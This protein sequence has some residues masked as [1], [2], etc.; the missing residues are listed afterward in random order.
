MAGEVALAGASALDEV[1]VSEAV[2]SALQ[3]QRESISGVN[4][5]EEAINLLK[6]ERAFQGAAR[7]VATVDRLLSEMMSLVR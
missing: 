1:E 4:L 6:F 7:Y 2:L 5:D 3:A